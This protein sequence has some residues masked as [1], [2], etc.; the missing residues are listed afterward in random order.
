MKL[1]LILTWKYLWIYRI[2]QSRVTTI[3]KLLLSLLKTWI[4]SCPVIYNETKNGDLLSLPNSR[5]ASPDHRMLRAPAARFCGVLR[6]LAELPKLS[7]VV[8]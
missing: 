2:E 4:G 3:V 7:N 1:T 8:N 5:S 6:V